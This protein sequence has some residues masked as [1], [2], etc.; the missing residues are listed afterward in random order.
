[1]L[2]IVGLFC[3]AL[4]AFVGG[5]TV[6]E[7]AHTTPGPHMCI[8]T[9]EYMPV[10][11]V[12]G[13]TY[14]NMCSMKCE[15]VAEYHK[16]ICGLPVCACP[17]IYQPVC[18]QDGQTYGN[19]CELRCAGVAFFQEG[20]CTGTAQ[21]LIPPGVGKRQAVIPCICTFIYQPV[22]GSNGQTFGNECTLRCDARENP[23]LSKLHEGPCSGT[24]LVTFSP[25]F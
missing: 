25:D 18:G 2:T 1:M 16:G 6:P 11:G 10:C 23:S 20:P 9:M 17:R 8:C 22:C 4:V 3:V 12:D 21:T 15:G 14:P 19:S 24:E 13:K 5:A 7:Q